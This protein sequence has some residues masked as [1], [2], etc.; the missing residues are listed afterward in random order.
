MHSS[1][2]ALQKTILVDWPII[3]RYSTNILESIAVCWFRLTREEREKPKQFAEIR[4]MLSSTLRILL[5]AL[6]SHPE[7]LENIKTFVR[8]DPRLQGLYQP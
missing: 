3:D 7:T 5:A 2:T 1:I 8:E 4:S 6:Q